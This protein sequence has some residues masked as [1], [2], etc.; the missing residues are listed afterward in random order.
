MIQII[1]LGDLMSL[2]WSS[3]DSLLL[4]VLAD[5]CQTIA[6]K[7]LIFTAAE[8]RIFLDKKMRC[9]GEDSNKQKIEQQ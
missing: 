6:L 4:T 2:F 8:T 9:L 5:L 7:S 3:L 1:T